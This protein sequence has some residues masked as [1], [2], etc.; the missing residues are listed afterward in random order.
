MRVI[1]I[2]AGLGPDNMSGGQ[3]RFGLALTQALQQSG[4]ELVVRDRFGRT[5]ATSEYA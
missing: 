2:F 4:V 5:P 1:E 3:A